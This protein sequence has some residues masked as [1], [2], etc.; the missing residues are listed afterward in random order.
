MEAGSDFEETSDPAIEIDN[1]R[2]GF[3]NP[4]QQFQ[5]RA[6]AR[7]VSANDADHIALD[8]VEIDVANRPERLG[9]RTTE[10]MAETIHHDIAERGDPG[11]SVLDLVRLAEAPN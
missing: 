7:A 11:P 1:A 4:A 9:L 8:D 6:L 10:W 5:Q 3:A 2:G